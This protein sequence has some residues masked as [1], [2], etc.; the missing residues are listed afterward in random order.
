MSHCKNNCKRLT[1]HSR[2]PRLSR[3]QNTSRVLDRPLTVDLLGENSA[4]C[5]VG[6]VTCQNERFRCIRNASIS[7]DVS[8]AFKALNA[9]VCSS[10]HTTS[11]VVVLLFSSTFSDQIDKRPRNSRVIQFYFTKVACHAQESRTW[12]TVFGTG[13]SRTDFNFLGFGRHPC[14]SIK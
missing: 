2:V 10:F 5:L 6:R 4:T 3:R 8:A 14:S 12:V 9:C 13:N 7:S 11:M 1:F